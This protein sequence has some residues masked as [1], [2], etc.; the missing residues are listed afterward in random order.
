MNEFV[1]QLLSCSSGLEWDGLLAAWEG[2]EHS[3]NPAA[4]DLVTA[5]SLIGDENAARRWGTE[6]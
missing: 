2:A 6:T 5:V 1:Y 4:T 3:S